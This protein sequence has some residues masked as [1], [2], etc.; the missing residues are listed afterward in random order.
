MFWERRAKP[1][2]PRP[3]SDLGLPEELM[4]VDAAFVSGHNQITYLVAGDKYWRRVP[5]GWAPQTWYLLHW[6]VYLVV[7]RLRF[8]T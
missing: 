8:G 3:L 7:D 6:G 2:Y 4:S 1:G 5:S